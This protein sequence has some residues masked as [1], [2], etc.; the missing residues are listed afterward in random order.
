[1]VSIN[2]KHRGCLIT[3]FK[4]LTGSEAIL[5]GVVFESFS[6]VCVECIV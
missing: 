6:G 5:K 2:R 4:C 3:C 1:M